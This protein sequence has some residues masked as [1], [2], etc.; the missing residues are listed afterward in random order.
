MAFLPLDSMTGVNSQMVVLHLNV[1]V[2][3]LAVASFRN[4]DSGEWCNGEE[5]G[6]GCYGCECHQ[7]W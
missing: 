2:N 5:F 7:W 1:V 3:Y 4:E 6:L